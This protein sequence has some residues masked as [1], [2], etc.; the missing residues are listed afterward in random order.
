MDLMQ[1]RR[2]L[3]MMHTSEI[4]YLANAEWTPGYIN[5]SG[6]INSASADIL[7]YSNQIAIPTPGTYKI[8]GISGTDMNN[9]VN[10]RLHGYDQQGNWIEQITYITSSLNNNYEMVAEISSNIHYIRLSTG[11]YYTVSMVRI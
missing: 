6:G 9:A 2:K 7:H 1:I 8:T 11:R 10:N 4:N 3:M 5:A